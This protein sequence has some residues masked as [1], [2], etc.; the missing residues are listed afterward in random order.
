LGI[1]HSYKL[2]RLVFRSHHENYDPTR[3]SVD[4][5]DWLRDKLHTLRQ[6]RGNDPVTA[7][8]Q[9]ERDLLEE[10][11][12]TPAIRPSVSTNPSTMR[13]QNTAFSHPQSRPISTPQQKPAQKRYESEFHP[14]QSEAPRQPNQ[15][16]D[17]KPNIDKL[18]QANREN[19]DHT[20]RS[21]TPNYY[22]SPQGTFDRAA[23]VRQRSATPN[24]LLPTGTRQ[25]LKLS[26]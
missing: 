1:G 8:R 6:K 22:A 10:L 5:D 23:A 11:K 20:F 15:P 13:Q 3:D 12:S 2:T 18:R 4:P 16:W 19:M 26:G 9:V 17:F 24:I 7:R 21:R 14:P 25:P